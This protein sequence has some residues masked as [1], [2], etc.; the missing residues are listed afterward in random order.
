MSRRPGRM[1]LYEAMQTGAARGM[2]RLSGDAPREAAAEPG[3]GFSGVMRVPAGIVM[4]AAGGVLLLL[5][6]VYVIGYTRAE[7]RIQDDSDET[8]LAEA[9]NL[10]DPD[11][12]VPAGIGVGIDEVDQPGGGTATRRPGAGENG[13]GDPV[14]GDGGS[15]GAASGRDA[16]DPADAL[17]DRGTGGGAPPNPDGAGRAAEAS[18]NDDAEGAE[19]LFGNRSDWGR[20]QSDPRRAGFYYWI[21][22]ET[23]RTGAVRLCEFLRSRGL[24]A[25]AV[26]G[27]NAFLRVAVLPGQRQRRDPRNPDPD[28]DR[29]EEAIERAGRAWRQAGGTSDLGD[30]YQSLQN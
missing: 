13:D 22:A 11:A 20:I 1:P 24:E 5:I 4:I 7:S 26:P 9:R 10:W 2:R 19:A 28:A 15:A 6:A 17:A 14:A 25:Y 3:S 8:L 21:V 29:L 23:T 27:N 18:E 30:K 16:R 12:P